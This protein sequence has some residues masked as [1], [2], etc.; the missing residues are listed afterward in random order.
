MATNVLT[1]ANQKDGGGKTTTAANL[2]IG[3]V[4]HEKKALLKEPYENLSK[5]LACMTDMEKRLNQTTAEL[6][7]MQDSL[8]KANRTDQ[9]S[10]VLTP[11]RR[12]K[13]A[14]YRMENLTDRAGGRLEEL[15]RIAY[16]RKPS[17]REALKHQESKRA[18]R[19]KGPASIEQAAR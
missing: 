11:L 16:A 17:V 8:S 14:I 7:G 12:L 6:R 18:A 13:D 2:G 1:I 10:T 4:R 9:A 5:L 3:F 19:P 15:E